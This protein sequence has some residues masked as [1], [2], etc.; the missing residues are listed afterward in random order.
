MTRTQLPI[1]SSCEL[2]VVERPTVSGRS[3]QQ[4]DGCSSNLGSANWYIKGGDQ[5]TG[6]YSGVV[7]TIADLGCHFASREG[8]ERV[9]PDR[10][11]RLSSYYP[12]A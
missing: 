2:S 8:I 11:L 5:G 4:I 7:G 12:V 6:G 1:V 10:V 3:D 9:L